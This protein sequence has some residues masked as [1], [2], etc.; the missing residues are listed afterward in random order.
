MIAESSR[1]GRAVWLIIPSFHPAV[2]GTGRQVQRLS[3]AS[4]RYLVLRK[5]PETP[6]M[7]KAKKMRDRALLAQEEA[8]SIYACPRDAS[9]C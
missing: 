9:R 8:M 6:D 3:R 7:V 5:W 1:T 2:G 4:I